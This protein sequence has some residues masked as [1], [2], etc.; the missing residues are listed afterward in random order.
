MKMNRTILVIIIL[1]LLI[2]VFAMI[3]TGFLLLRRNK[4]GNEKNNSNKPVVKQ[5]PQLVYGVND[6]TKF[7]NDYQKQ[8]WIEIHDQIYI[9]YFTP[10]NINGK[11]LLQAND[12]QVFSGD[13]LITDNIIALNIQSKMYDS[14]TPDGKVIISNVGSLLNV[15]GLNGTKADVLQ[16]SPQ[17]SKL[18]LDDSFNFIQYP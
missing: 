6:Q 3:L 13:I 11:Y 12:D 7:S 4:N 9:L 1:V 10:G 17:I 5:P 14:E 16:S 8:Y 18:T 2:F 15:F